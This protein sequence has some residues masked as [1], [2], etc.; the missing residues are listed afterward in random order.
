MNGE[1]KQ[2]NIRCGN[3][4]EII[5]GSMDDARA[6]VEELFKVRHMDRG[7]GWNTPSHW[8]SKNKLYAYN[9]NHKLTVEV[10]SVKVLK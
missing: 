1:Q 8:D 4:S 10:G 9:R 7:G 3:Y 2:F 6:R 5:S